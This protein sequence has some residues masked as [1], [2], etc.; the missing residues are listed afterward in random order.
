[1]NS[2]LA[3]QR[4]RPLT[5]PEMLLERARKFP[6]APLF[7]CGDVRRDSQ[8]MVDAA[9]SAGGMLRGAG[10]E[11]GQ[12]VALMSSNRPELLDMI[13]GCAWIGA[14]A[15]PV[16]TASRGEQL[17]HVLELDA[18]ITVGETPDEAGTAA[19]PGQGR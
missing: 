13:L 14:V 2:T 6:S 16:N 3:E 15:V 5:I 7:R 9:A 19:E 4:Q 1:M 11:R 17:R 8:A 12:T 18:A 10:I